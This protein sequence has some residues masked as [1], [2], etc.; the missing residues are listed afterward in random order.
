MRAHTHAP[1]PPHPNDTR[2]HMLMGVRSVCSSVTMRLRFLAFAGRGAAARLPALLCRFSAC[3]GL[4]AV[5]PELPACANCVRLKCSR[6]ASRSSSMVVSERTRSRLANSC[7]QAMA[8]M[9]REGERGGER[10]FCLIAAHNHD[11]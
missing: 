2:P 6:M 10:P 8:G 3:T 4:K 1:T 11:V 5:R 9:T 7:E